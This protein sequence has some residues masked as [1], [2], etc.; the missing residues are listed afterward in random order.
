MALFKIL[1]GDSSRIDTNTTPFHDGYAYFTP[2]DGGFYIDSEDNGT[3]R[4]I[5]INPVQQAGEEA[6]FLVVTASLRASDWQNGSQVLQ[7]PQVTSHSN[8]MIGMPQNVTSEQVTV[9]KA[10]G[11]YISGQGEGVLT[12]S[13]FG[14]VPQIDI[15]V[16]LLIDGV[17][18]MS[19]NSVLYANKWS[20][21]RQTISVPGLAAAGNGVIGLPSTTTEDQARIA[22][23]SGLYV[24]GQRDNE[25]DI[26]VSGD[27]PT[28]N[29]PIVVILLD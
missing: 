9:A 20:N 2:D 26:A 23:A 1:K 22:A 4:R 13:A 29:I 14:K 5:R 3:Q 17:D 24:C 18:A 11:L 12:I 6:N 15:P 28:E 19:V 27:I 16:S 25:V 8:G 21:G 7:V 10:A